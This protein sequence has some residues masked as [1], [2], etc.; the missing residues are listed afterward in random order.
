MDKNRTTRI[1][2]DPFTIIGAAAAVIAAGLTAVEMAR[3][4][5]P[6]LPSNTRRRML[7]LV[8]EIEEILKYLQA[9]L[10]LIEGIFSR[11]HYPEGPTLRLGNGAL[12]TPEDFKRYEK[13]SDVV[14]GRLKQ[15]NK[16]S[17]R[18]ERTVS[19][20]DWIEPKEIAIYRGEGVDR[21]DRILTHRDLT[22]ESAWKELR[23]VIRMYENFVGELRAQLS[24]A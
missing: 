20:V 24:Q 16:L 8:S 12:I 2:P 17:L 15:I 9:D 4:Y 3:K 19:R 18:V 5:W 7:E 23:D 14:F 21:L 22:V 6:E 13:I 10:E 1:D 11:A